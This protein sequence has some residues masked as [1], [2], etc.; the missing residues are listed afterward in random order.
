MLGEELL[1]VV[2]ARAPSQRVT[3]RQRFTAYMTN[4]GFGQDAFGR[5]F[6]VGATRGANMRVAGILPP[7]PRID[8]TL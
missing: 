5:N 6:V 4:H 7:L 8:P 2:T 1:L 3:D